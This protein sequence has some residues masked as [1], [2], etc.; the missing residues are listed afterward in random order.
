[1]PDLNFIPPALID[2]VEVLTGGAS[3]VYGSDAVAGV[4]NFIMKNNFEGVQIDA[5]YVDRRT[6]Q[7]QPAGRRANT[8]AAPASASR[9][10]TCP[11]A[12]VWAG[13][14][15]TVTIT[16]GANS[17]DDKG[18]VEFYMG[19][20]HID[21]VLEAKYDWSTCG[22]STNNTNTL[23]QY[24]GGSSN[25]AAGRLDPQQ[26]IVGGLSS[27]RRTPRRL[28]IAGRAG[29][30]RPSARRRSP[31]ALYNF[32]PLNYLQR[33]DDR[34]HG[35]RVL[36]LRDQPVARRLF[37]LHVHGRPLGRPDRAVRRLLRRPAV[38]HPLQRSAADGGRRPTPCA[39]EAAGTA[40][41]ATATQLG[42]RNVEGG[43]RISD[44]DHT[45]YRL[46][47]GAKG[48]LGSGWTYDVS[49]PVRPTS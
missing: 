16:G 33:P 29:V 18:N 1:M 32:A 37:E 35:G 44:I 2:R 48:D 3:A 17:P 4:V 23:Q 46:V 21:P 22:L 45:D 49:A 25:D 15:N 6:R 13:H 41:N 39:G 24:C 5:E 14:R 12:S 38:Q 31:T 8:S 10:S 47:I 34:Y 36:A 28:T 40:A 11:R 27:R 19:Y 9:R 26:L 30:R 7:Q 43:R 20:T 42:R